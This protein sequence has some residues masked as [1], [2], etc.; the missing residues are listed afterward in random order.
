MLEKRRRRLE[1]QGW[2]VGGADDFLGL[3]PA[4]LAY[5]ELKLLLAGA[6]KTRRRDRGLSQVEAAKLIGTSQSRL[7]RIEAGDPSVS[8]DLL[9]RSNLLLGASKQDLANDL[10]R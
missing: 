2:T 1:Q 3:S 4:E 10:A 8:V 6:L 5:I 9:V 7:S